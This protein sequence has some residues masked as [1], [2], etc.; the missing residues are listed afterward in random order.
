MSETQILK[1]CAINRTGTAPTNQTQVSG[2]LPVVQVN[3][4]ANGPQTH[5]QQRSA[6]SA[7]GGARPAVQSGLPMVNVKMGTN[8]PQQV[9]GG[10]PKVQHVQTRAKVQVL[11]RSALA[12]APLTPDQLLLCRHLVDKYLTELKAAAEAPK[13]EGQTEEGDVAAKAAADNVKLGE[14]TIKAIDV[15]MVAHTAA[16]AFVDQAPAQ[17]AAKAPP[18][19]R[20]VTGAR[21]QGNASLAPRRVARPAA[22]GKAPPPMVSVKMNGEQP[23][24]ETPPDIADLVDPAEAP[25]VETPTQG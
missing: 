4:N 25:S 5:N 6:P 22:N 10:G 1:S 24:V 20:V 3:M 21:T 9:Q 13:P 11:P 19:P 7:A 8:G 15:A 18:P 23:V 2:P 14:E 16:A 17:A 12:E